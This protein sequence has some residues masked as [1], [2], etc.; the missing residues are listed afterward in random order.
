MNLKDDQFQ[1]HTITEVEPMDSGWSITFDDG[2]S[3]FV[4]SDSPVKPKTGMKARLYGKGIGYAVRGLFLDGIEVYYRT[5]VE[6]EEYREIM[7]FGADAAEWLRRWDAG[8]TVWSIEMG[9]LGPGYEQCIH[10]TAAEIL[11]HLLAE[12]YDVA[13][14]EIP[15]LW[16]DD[17]DAIEK[18]GLANE[19][20]NALGLSG[21]QWG[22]AVSIATALYRQGPRGVMSDVRVKD[23]H[24]QVQRTFPQAVTA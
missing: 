14:W 18:M 2:F 13:R 8:D 1:D 23:R 19:T 17:R 15:E 6:E 22:A 16:K 9:G 5:E 11:R 20:I 10:I 21:A 3:F 4:K 7:L 24:I 12:K